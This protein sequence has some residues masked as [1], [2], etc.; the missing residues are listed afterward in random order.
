MYMQYIENVKQRHTDILTSV[1]KNNCKTH[2]YSKSHSVLH[3]R[4]CVVVCKSYSTL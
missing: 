3:N 4:I 1:T 2:T